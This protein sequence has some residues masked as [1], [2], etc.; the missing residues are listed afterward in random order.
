[1]RL[2]ALIFLVACGAPEPPQT[3]EP[4]AKDA[5]AEFSLVMREHYEVA[6]ESRN[7]LIRGDLDGARTAAAMMAKLET[8]EVP[9]PWKPHLT[10]MEDAA[11]KLSE[12]TDL[13]IAGQAVGTLAKTCGDCHES[14]GGGPKK[15]AAAALANDTPP[16]GHMPQHLWVADR[17]WLGI[18]ANEPT[19]FQTSAKFLA[20]SELH[21]LADEGAADEEMATLEK[22]VH[23]LAGSQGSTA[24]RGEQASLYGHM[25]TNCAQCHGR[26][27]IVP[28]LKPKK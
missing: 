12:A 18:I 21:Q 8:P 24:N 27:G 3:P 5:K 13:D 28:S 6:T 11:K 14:V 23:E 2:A 7:A 22:Q 19:L 9:E 25:I 10:A 17:L 20:E 26:A 1:M 16:E 4:S 15:D